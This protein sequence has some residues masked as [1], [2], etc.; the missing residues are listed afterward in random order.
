MRI[1]SLLEDDDLE[2]TSGLSAAVGAYLD[3]PRPLFTR[4]PVSYR[5]VPLGMRTAILRAIA[6]L[7]PAG[8][9]EFP[10]W[11]I[12]RR[13]DEGLRRTGRRL[14]FAGKRS[15]CIIT[16]DLD[17]RS[18]LGAIER[19][20]SVERPLG[21][22]SSFGF[23]PTESWPTENVA[24]LIVAEGC[25]VYWHDIAHNGRLPYLSRDGI[26]AEFDRVAERHPWAVELMRT[27]RAG[28]LLASRALLDVVAERF[29]I[30]MSIPDTER[31]GPYGGSAGCGTVFPFR[32]GPLLEL[33]LTMP[34]EVYLRQVYGLS[35]D[36]AL[37]IWIEKLTYI[38]SVGGVAVFNIHPVWITS[39]HPDL[40]R[41]FQ[42]FVEAVAEASDILVTTPTGLASA[43][44][45][46][47]S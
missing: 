13:I 19:I 5:K 47:S 45:V 11:P 36:E 35:A 10:Q 20:R 46:T 15:A 29:T 21:I 18:E 44:R 2:G 7:R 39:K 43:V 40:F 14:S 33:P 23:V 25:E 28:Q 4:L 32:Y 31:D 6:R 22:V 30:D 17:S 24:R 27:F 42:R 38:R 41:A 12:E 8:A 26:R 37:R 1:A 34:Q 16:H 3:S 9:M